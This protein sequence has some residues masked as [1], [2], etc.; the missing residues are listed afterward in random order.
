MNSH[1]GKLRLTDDAL[2][3]HGVVVVAVNDPAR[4]LDNFDRSFEDHGQFSLCWRHICTA[5]S[6]RT[7]GHSSSTDARHTVARMIAFSGGSCPSLTL[8]K[9]A[10]AI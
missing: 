8:S 7:A 10:P 6:A 2:P 3:V 1:K 9:Y 4:E 5:P